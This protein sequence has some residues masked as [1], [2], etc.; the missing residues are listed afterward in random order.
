[1]SIAYWMANLN[2]EFNRFVVSVVIMVLVVQ[3]SVGFGTLISSLAPSTNV[4]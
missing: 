2:N 1:M 4:G 3:C